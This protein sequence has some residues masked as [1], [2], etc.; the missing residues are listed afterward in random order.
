VPC[1]LHVEHGM[2][3]GADGVRMSDPA[4]RAFRAGGTAALRAAVARASA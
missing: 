4:M 3:H 1:E 2:Y